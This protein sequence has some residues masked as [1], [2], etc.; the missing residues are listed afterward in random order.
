MLTEGEVTEQIYLQAFC[1]GHVVLVFGQTSGCVPLTLVQKAREE[2]R[3][4]R[5]ASKDDRFDEIWCVFDRDNHPNIKQ[6]LAEA[7][8]AGVNVAFSNPCFELWLVWHLEDCTAHV[9][10]NV[11]QRRSRELGLT[12]GKH[13]TREAIP[14]L[15]NG[16]S[17]AKKRAQELDSRRERDGSE[18]GSNPHSD[19]WRLV[20][21]LQ[22]EA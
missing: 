16:F 14:K 13:I 20:E 17:A 11:I 21:V 18:Y 15:E 2:L 3:A 22:A 1:G 10:R 8:N 4:N 6:A 5:R 9:E 19:V 7:R 12:E